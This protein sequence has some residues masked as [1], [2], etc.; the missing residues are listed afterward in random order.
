MKEELQVNINIK[1]MK[2][3]IIDPC[4]FYINKAWNED[5]V[6]TGEFVGASLSTFLGRPS[7]QFEYEIG[8]QAKEFKDPTELNRLL[9]R[10]YNIPIDK[11]NDITCK[12]AKEFY[13]MYIEK[14]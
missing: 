11:A 8:Q 10:K 7:T 2:C 1:D 6:A 4:P 13:K 12:G 14:K 3:E 9:V 5:K